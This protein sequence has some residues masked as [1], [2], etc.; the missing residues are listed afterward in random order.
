MKIKL[1]M[2]C[3][4]WFAS[5]NMLAADVTGSFS[6]KGAGLLNCKTFVKEREERSNVYYMIGGWLDGFISAHNKYVEGT[7]DITTFET[8]ELLAK[9]IDNHCRA[10]PKDRLYP[11]VNSIIAKFVPHRIQT[12]SPK[13]DIHAG[14]RKTRLYQE[15]LRRVQAELKERGYFNGKIDGVYNNSM[16]DAIKAFQASLKFEQTGFPD[17]TTLWRLLHK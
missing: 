16:I 1:L 7:Y 11:V 2:F 10:N 12:S 14:K 5:G 8:S 15:T 6:I 13:I 9:V 4:L 3:A 17:Q